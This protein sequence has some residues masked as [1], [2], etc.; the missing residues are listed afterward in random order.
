[1][2]L[3][4]AITAVDVVVVNVERRLVIGGGELPLVLLDQV[5]AIVFFVGRRIG[6]GHVFLIRR[7]QHFTA[8][9]LAASAKSIS[10]PVVSA[11]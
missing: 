8:D 3:A 6:P 10:E 7:F 5:V 9:K 4:G 2:E 1:M 11:T